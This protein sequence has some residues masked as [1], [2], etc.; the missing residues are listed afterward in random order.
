M[1]PIRKTKAKTEFGDFQ[2]PDE[3]AH[4]VCRL[5]S[6]QGVNPSAI[7]EPNCGRGNLLLA[8]VRTFSGAERAI[9]FEINGSYVNEAQD[10]LTNISHPVDAT[11]QH[12]DFFRIDWMGILGSIPEPILIIGNPPWVTSA[13]LSRIESENLPEKSNFQNHQGIDAITGKSN[14]DISEWMLIREL[15]WLQNRIGTLAM[16][17]KTSVARKVLLHAWKNDFR[18]KQASIYLIDAPHYFGAAVDACL[19]YVAVGVASQAQ[20]CQVYESLDDTQLRTTIGFRN[21]GLIA[22][23][24]HFER[25]KHLDGRSHYQWRSGVKHDAAKIMELKRDGDRYINGLGE[26]VDLE[27]DY[28]YPMFKSSDIANGSMQHPTRWM[29]IPQKAVGDSTR[30]IQMIAPKTWS[31]L[32][33]HSTKLDNRKSS[34]YRNRPRFSIFGVGEYSFSPWKVVVS[35]FYKFFRFRVVGP[36]DKRPVVLDDTCYFLACNSEDEAR[37]LAQLLNSTPAREFYSAYVF[38]D[39]KR[40]ITIALLR[41]L[42]LLALAKELGV[43]DDYRL[44]SGDSVHVESDYSQMVL[45]V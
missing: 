13:E 26:L 18:M 28:L 44:F 12:G 25:W 43:E 42:D 24:T 45:P 39:A 32:I 38:R 1:S 9:G 15:E 16:L 17:C 40:P 27:P 23:L 21:G 37:F 6:Q 36:I 19:L 2:T 41:R 11:V 4:K 10:R 7:L 35:G 34:I 5:L 29:L 31:Y 22:D 20:E 14:F 3:L 33:N 30:E 8:A